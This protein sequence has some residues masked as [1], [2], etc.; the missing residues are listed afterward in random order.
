MDAV[1]RF[2]ELKLGVALVPVMVLA[3]RPG[4][5]SLRLVEPRLSRLVNLARR[6]DVPLT[7]AAAMRNVLVSTAHALADSGTSLVDLA[8]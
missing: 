2:V 4:L 6:Q 3:D 8:D 1:L 5:Q 7:R